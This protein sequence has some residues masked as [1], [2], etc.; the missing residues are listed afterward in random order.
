M[1][2]KQPSR[3][4]DSGDHNAADNST[5]RSLAE[6]LRLIQRDVASAKSQAAEAKAENSALKRQI[7]L[8]KQNPVGSFS[9]KS[10]GNQAQYDA[11]ISILNELIR[12]LT[13]LEEGN[14]IELENHIRAAIKKINFRNKLIKLADNSSVGW[15]IVEEYLKSDLA[16]DEEEDRFIRRCESAAIE[17]RR[18]KQ[19]SG[20]KG[21]PNSGRGRGRPSNEQGE[22]KRPARGEAQDFQNSPY[23]EY[24]GY[25][26]YGGYQG[27]A[28]GPMYAQAPSSHYHQRPH[29][30]YMQPHGNSPYQRGMGPC[31]KCGG[32]HLVRYCPENDRVT[33][34]VQ[35]RIEDDYYGY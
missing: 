35:E 13:E 23:P 28:P 4:A 25:Q 34:E 33:S 9:L 17:K 30:H 11:N 14:E 21:R 2:R 8:Q 12:A 29:G 7:E 5:L 16:I 3:G 27:Q 10:K 24:H 20:N 15:A 26:G 18:I 32:P 6:Q 22:A 31:F 1:P 19:E